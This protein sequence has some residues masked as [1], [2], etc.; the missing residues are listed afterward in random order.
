M[1][2]SGVTQGARGS[3]LSISSTLAATKALRDV[4]HKT[5]IAPNRRAQ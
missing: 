3:L 4:R 2:M 5:A 1:V